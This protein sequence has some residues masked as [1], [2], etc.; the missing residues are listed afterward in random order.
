MNKQLQEIDSTSIQIPEVRVSDF[1]QKNCVL[2][3]I[4]PP[5]KSLQVM[6]RG[7]K[8][9]IRKRYHKLLDYENATQKLKNNGDGEQLKSVC[10]LYCFDLIQ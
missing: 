2:S 6:F 9:V 10:L 4:V 7:P 3:N 1:S 8:E 5:L